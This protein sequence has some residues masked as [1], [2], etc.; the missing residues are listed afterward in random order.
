MKNQPH[1]I[2][3]TS[4]PLYVVS[5]NCFSSRAVHTILSHL[6]LQLSLR[7][8]YEE[9]CHAKTGHYPHIHSTVLTISH[10]WWLIIPSTVLTISHYWW[11]V[12]PF[13]STDHQSILMTGHSF[14]QYSQSFITDD[15][16]FPSQYW[17][18][19][20]TDDWSFTPQH[21]PSV[22]TDDW[23]FASIW[24]CVSRKWR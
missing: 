11:L 1:F 12:I 16:S 24:D 4:F 20:N 7:C 2:N 23:S 22:I 5:G 17:Q 3:V 10:Y 13:H 9:C 14:P 6:E 18:S 19:V 21:W 15:W 8:F